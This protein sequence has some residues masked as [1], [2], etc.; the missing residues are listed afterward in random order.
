MKHLPSLVGVTI[1]FGIVYFLTEVTLTGRQLA[2]GIA[3]AVV[4]YG[5]TMTWHIRNILDD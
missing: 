3:A 5:A 1:L 2:I 4:V